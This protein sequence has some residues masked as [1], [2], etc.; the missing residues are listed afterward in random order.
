MTALAKTIE[1]PPE[2]IAEIQKN[3]AYIMNDLN[4]FVTD[5]TL[6]EDLSNTICFL[7]SYPELSRSGPEKNVMRAHSL[8]LTISFMMEQREAIENLN[9]L[10][11]HSHE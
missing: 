5:D 6:I 7:L 2:R 3:E 8:A 10:K 1:M 11:K 4:E 9:F